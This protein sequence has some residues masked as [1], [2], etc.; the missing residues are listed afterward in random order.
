[1]REGGRLVNDERNV[2]DDGLDAGVTGAVRLLRDRRIDARTPSTRAQSF[3]TLGTRLGAMRER[4][5][6]RKL[7]AIGVSCVAIAAAIGFGARPRF[8][9]R[10][11]SALTYTVNGGAP[12]AGGYILPAPAP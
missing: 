2:K 1:M 7:A 6:K 4:A 10:S 3:R 12:V 8:D 11:P 5:R 9:L